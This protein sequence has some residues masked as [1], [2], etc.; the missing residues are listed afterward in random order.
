MISFR[1]VISEE[2]T[3]LGVLRWRST[4]RNEMLP[5]GELEEKGEMKNETR[6]ETKWR[7]GIGQGVRKKVVAFSSPMV[8]HCRTAE[9][10]H[11]HT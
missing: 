7:N 10:H 5:A 11:I 6:N 2:E 3:P 4:K 8:S 1:F 9:F